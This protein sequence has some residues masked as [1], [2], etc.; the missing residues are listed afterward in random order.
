MEFVKAVDWTGKV[1]LDH[2]KRLAKDFSVFAYPTTVL[3]TAKCNLIVFS[4]NDI[5]TWFFIGGRKWDDPRMI[6]FFKR[7]AA[8]MKSSQR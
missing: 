5:Y 2:E 3:L 1:V 4:E 7:A 8:E 6:E